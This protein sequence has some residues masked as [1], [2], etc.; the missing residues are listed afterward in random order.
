MRLTDE[1]LSLSDKCTAE[2]VAKGFVLGTCG[3]M[4]LL[5]CARSFSISVDI[6]NEVADVASIDCVGFTRD[7]SLID[8]QYDTAFTNTF[9]TRAVIP[10]QDTDTRY[11]LCVSATGSWRDTNDGLCEPSYQ[12]FVMEENSPVPDN[13]LPVARIVFDEYCWR[14]DETGFVP[15][16]LYIA[17]LPQYEELAQKFLL[18]LKELDANLP[19][20][21]YTESKDAVK[22]FWPAVQQLLI[23]MDKE[24]ETMSPM[25]L[26]A[27]IQK[28]ASSFYCACT[29]DDYIDISDPKQFVTFIHTPYNLKNAYAIIRDGVSLALSISERV[30]SFDAAPVEHHEAR[31]LASP[32][33]ERNQ[34][35]P[36]VKFG[37]AQIKI[38][39]N[40]PGATIF[41]TTDGST[42]NKS[43]QSGTT[44]TVDSGF[45]DNWHK[46]PPKKV[47]IKAVA[48]KEGVYSSV[49]TFEAQIRKGNPFIGKEI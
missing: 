40:A 9:D 37:N 38:T 44:V 23:A 12:F 25:K 16:C 18:A 27:N 48:F 46:E 5:P 36:M 39:N 45:S 11:Y 49:E 22:I 14:I 19:Q 15:P 29:L 21:L 43:S 41:Y 26:L 34:L 42:P 30:K 32:S 35:R 3:R 6:N 24:R 10:S 1:I 7:G 17:S 20:K 13:A 31:A 33:I 2:L 47:V 28:L 4:G 8:I